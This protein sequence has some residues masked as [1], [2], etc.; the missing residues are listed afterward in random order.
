VLIHERLHAAGY[1]QRVSTAMQP[2]L[3]DWRASPTR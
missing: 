3:E 1:D 2:M